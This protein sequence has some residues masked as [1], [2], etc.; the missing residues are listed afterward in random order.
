MAELVPDERHRAELVADIPRIPFAF[1][2]RPVTLPA[3]WSTATNGAYVLL[4]E[5]YRPDATEAAT[6][7]WPVIDLP[8]THL[9]IATHPTRIAAALHDLTTR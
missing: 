8:G 9:A 3:D 2:E 5:V 1:F 4:S 6:R 7:G